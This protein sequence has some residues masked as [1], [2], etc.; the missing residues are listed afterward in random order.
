[1]ATVNFEDENEDG[2]LSTESDT[3]KSEADEVGD[4]SNRLGGLFLTASEDCRE[5]D[6]ETDYLVENLVPKDSMVLLTGPPK[7]GKT[8]YLL[9]LTESLIEGT[10]FLGSEVEQTDVLYLTEQRLSSFKSEYVFECGLEDSDRLHYASEGDTLGADLEKLMKGVVVAAY[11]TGAELFIV[12]TF[13]SFSGLEDEEENS[14]GSVKTALQT[15]RAYCSKIGLTVIIVHHDRK[16]GGSVIEAGRGSNVFAGEP[17]IVFG[18]RKDADQDNARRLLSNGR[19]SDVPEQQRIALQDGSYRVLG[20]SASGMDA[21]TQA[22]L[23]ALPRSK[24][25]ALKTK[26]VAD[27]LEEEGMET[28]KATV[29]RKLDYLE[30][31]EDS[32]RQFEGDGRGSPKMY[33]RDADT[34]FTL[35]GED[36]V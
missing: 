14:S 30:G 23:D 24:D 5:G 6:G 27:A 15:V 17:D 9:R 28:S 21:T 10:D 16:S 29:R 4:D 7:I 33:Y 22:V 19:F 2:N 34:A 11:K 25:E 3:E 31:A 13:L 18:L 32:V 20:S 26:E 12:D 8:T 1:M 36:E 35:H